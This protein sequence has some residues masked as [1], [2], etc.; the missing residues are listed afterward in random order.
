[1]GIDCSSDRKCGATFNDLGHRSCR[2]NALSFGSGERTRLVVGDG[3]P[4]IANFLCKE[5]CGKAPQ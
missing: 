2:D 5:H 1:L 4:A 3:A